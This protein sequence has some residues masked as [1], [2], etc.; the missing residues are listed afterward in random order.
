MIAIDTNVF[1]GAIQT[2]DLAIRTSARRAIK[3]LYRNGEELICFPQNLIEF[4]SAATRPANANGL[5]LSPEQAA[6]YVDRCFRHWFALSRK[7]RRFFRRGESSCFSI[8]SPG[9]VSTTHAWQRRF[10]YFKCHA[11]SLSIPV[12]S[13]G[14]CI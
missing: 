2:F 4:W 12:V 9:S 1:V 13:R 8:A 11:F 5:G 10:S 3:V 7:D 14:M 6:R